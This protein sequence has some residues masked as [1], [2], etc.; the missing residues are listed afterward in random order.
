MQKIGILSFCLICFLSL[1][2]AAAATSDELTMPIIKTGVEKPTT[3]MQWWAPLPAGDC[4]LFE[5]EGFCLHVTT[6]EVSFHENAYTLC[7]SKLRLR[8]RVEGGYSI[9]TRQM[10]GHCETY[11]GDTS[12]LVADMI[13]EQTW[14]RAGNTAD[15]PNWLPVLKKLQAA[16]AQ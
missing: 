6:R 9:E 15:D 3:Y 14:H 12:A 16:P 1:S 4:D 11:H 13:P 5:I 8:P 2:R 7:G 10:G